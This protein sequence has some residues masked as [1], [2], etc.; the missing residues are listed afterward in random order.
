MKLG[1]RISNLSPGKVTAILVSH[2]CAKVKS[3]FNGI[4]NNDISSVSISVT[5]LGCR[6]CN[7]A[8]AVD[9]FSAWRY[10]TKEREIFNRE[11]FLSAVTAIFTGLC[12]VIISIPD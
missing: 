3:R 11:K 4:G 10:G 8:P 5:H 6:S 12:Y 9:P 7:L 1:A 2:F